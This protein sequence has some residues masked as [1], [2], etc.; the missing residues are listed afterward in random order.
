MKGPY[1]SPLIIAAIAV[2]LVAM[3]AMVFGLPDSWFCGLLALACLLIALETAYREARV[4]AV[5]A[6]T[7]AAVLSGAAAYAAYANARGRRQP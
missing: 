5:T 7:A 3:V 4:W 6:V 1:V 2:V